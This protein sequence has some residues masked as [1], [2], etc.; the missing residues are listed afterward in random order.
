MKIKGL[1]TKSNLAV[2]VLLIFL[3]LFIF[4]VLDNPKSKTSGY[5][6]KTN[7]KSFAL[8]HESGLY[9][10]PFLLKVI[11]S[12]I[13]LL[14]RFTLDGNEPTEFSQ[15]LDKELP[16]EN[17][18][19]LRIALFDHTERSSEI[20]NRVFI[21]NE[22]TFP[23]VSVVTEPENLWGKELGIYTVGIDT[24]SPNY[25]KKGDIWKKNA[26]LTFI[27]SNNIVDIDMPVEIRISGGA[28]RHNPQK[29]LRV[30]A[31][32]ELGFKSIAYDFFNNP[33]NKQHKC[34]LLRNSGNDWDRTMF[35]D[36]LGQSLVFETDLDTQKFLPSVVYLNGEYWGIHNIREFYDDQYLKYEY[37]TK[38][39]SVLIVEPDRRNNG[40]PIIRDGIPEDAAYYIDL[41]NNADNFEYLVKNI[42]LSNYIDYFLVNIYT[43]NDDWPDN[44]I[45]MWKFKAN[46]FNSY[47]TQPLDGKWRW[48]LFDLDSSFGLFKSSS[49]SA[50]TLSYATQSKLYNKTVKTYEYWPTAIINTLLDNNNFRN[51]FINRYADL[52]NTNFSEEHVL[53]TIDY[54]SKQYSSEIQ[55]HINKWGGVKDKGGK[56]AFENMEKWNQN[57]EVLKE[58]A[59]NRPTHA[60]EHVVKRFNLS[61]VSKITLENI[62][63]Q[64]GYV[65][66]NSIDTLN[67]ISKEE[68]IYFNDVPITIKAYPNFGW[69]FVG[70]GNSNVSNSRNL[71]IVLSND[72]KL[73]PTFTQTWWGKYINWL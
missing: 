25:T 66:I 14:A 67:N 13:N 22:H 21:F 38:K 73:N 16:I 45:R 8:S 44:N 5:T 49:Y 30:C 51:N 12:D 3:L 54:L 29:T 69:K 70:W 34:I 59:R 58:F 53:Q 15:Q 46:Q 20:I 35:R 36:I 32:K 63:P 68:L 42:D 33:T 56:P 64:G 61:G 50:D 26:I 27:N 55:Q 9:K 10:D 1:L 28:T 48:L 19:V 2:T 47:A 31:K 60:R 52:L 43:A 23:V 7:S 57:I 11:T 39:E 40:G 4:I 62:K 37:G 18:T 24:K 41:I 65:R 71:E 6:E 17:N 72:I